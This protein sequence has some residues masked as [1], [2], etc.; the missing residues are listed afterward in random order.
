MSVRSAAGPG[1][2]NPVSIPLIGICVVLAGTVALV[3]AQLGTLGLL[4]VG[5]FVGLAVALLVVREREL[6]VTLVMI[7]SL[8]TVFHKSIGPIASDV[9]SGALSVYITSIDVL[10]LIAY[11]FWI[12]SGEFSRDLA[13]IWGKPVF[14]L[15]LVAIASTLPSTLVA[16]NLFLAAGELVR[17]IWMY[18]LFVYVALRVRTRRDLSFV[19][20][21]LLLVAVAQFAVSALQWRTGSSL[22][23]AFLGEAET[24]G[25]RTLDGSEFARPSGT[26]IHADFLAALVAPIALLSFA[27]AVE[28]RRRPWIRT[29]CIAVAAIGA[30]TLVLAQARAAMVGFGVG[31]VVLAVWYVLRGL[32]STR[33]VVA[34][35]GVLLLTALLFGGEVGGRLLGN[36]GTDQFQREVRSRIE[37]N[38][39]ALEMIG[40]H[41][42]I[43][44]GL[45][46]FEQVMEGYDRYGLIFAG[47]PVHNLYLLVT[48]ETGIVGAIGFALSAGAIGIAAL[49]AARLPSGLLSA[50]GAAVVATFI[51]FG[52]EELLTFSLRHDMPLAV[53]WLLAGLAVA[54]VRID[55]HE[56]ASPAPV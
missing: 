33:L 16:P 45:N 15:P 42:V 52:T 6:L 1:H 8:Q 18:G 13:T 10:L 41:A 54:C 26:V 40:D 39:I 11:G 12:A 7:G 17:M 23:L 9:S 50:T 44:V 29:V 53:F 48:A 30:G 25:V 38:E 19:V 4:A 56:R 55:L 37:L 51:F 21:V 3:A 47:H 24:L 28:I 35:S 32:I 5:S 49:R 20:G 43:G 36:F 14:M 2:A 22:G 46:N 27:V 31:L 34:A